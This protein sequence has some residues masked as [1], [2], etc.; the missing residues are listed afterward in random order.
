KKLKFYTINAFK[1]ARESG[2]GGRINTIMQ[3][4]F[5]ALSGVLP[6]EK[7]VACIKDSIKKSYG[8]KGEEIVAMNIK[9]V[10][11]ALE[12]LHE[13]PVPSAVIPG[14]KSRPAV[15][16]QSPPFVKN[17]LAKMMTGD[18]DELPVSAL[19]CDGTYPTATAQWEKRNIAREIP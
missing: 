10:D 11:A 15:P 12:F 18:G 14:V 7:A 3:V 19:P 16:A 9:A 17:V 5:F 2:M 6:R 8:K 4:C 1:V 13:V